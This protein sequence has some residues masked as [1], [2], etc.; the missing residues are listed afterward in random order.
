VMAGNSELTNV[1]AHIV[2][3][4]HLPKIK[5]KGEGKSN[6]VKSQ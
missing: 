3:L 1:I 4:N 2:P 5:K 6:S